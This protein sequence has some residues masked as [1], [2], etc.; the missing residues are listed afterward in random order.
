MKNIR[1]NALKE[2][3][4]DFANIANFIKENTSS[5]VQDILRDTIIEE[6]EKI[7]AEGFDKKEDETTDDET[8]ST[9]ENT[10]FNDNTEAE[11]T[12][13][14]ETDFE[15]DST[16][17]EGEESDTLETDTTVEV[18]EEEDSAPAD[19]SE[20]DDYKMDDENGGYDF[21]QADDETIVKVYKLLRNS[22]EVVVDLDNEKNKLELKD[23]QTGAEYLVNL[24]SAKDCCTNGT[25]D[26]GTEEDENDAYGNEE[27]EDD[28]EIKES[29][30]VE[31]EIMLNEDTNLGYTDNY[32]S[33]DVMTTPSV[34]EP[35]K[36]VN[37]WDAGVPKSKSKPWAGKNTPKKGVPFNEEDEMGDEDT[38][39]ES[40][41]IQTK[42]ASNWGLNHTAKKGNKL[43]VKDA[44]TWGT[45][46]KG[47]ALKECGDTEPI[48]EEEDLEEA[49]LSQSRWNDTHAAHNRVPAANKDSYRRQGMQKTSKGTTYRENG[50]SMD[51]AIIKKHKQIV[52]ENKE[53]KKTLTKLHN[54][55]MEAAVTNMNLGQIVKL[56]KENSTTQEEKNEIIAR[57]GKEAK[58][59][60]ESKDLYVKISNELQKKNT[61][62]INEEKQ[63]TTEGSKKI[64]E[65][66]IYASKDLMSSLELMHKICK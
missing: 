66:T 61:M 27:F 59:I 30:M 17:D 15:D 33:K 23:N 49:N 38:I 14:E 31:I 42:D 4:A 34:E 9:E 19:W 47:K 55:V 64:N 40:E 12:S 20:F 62:S 16:E 63:F 10:E 3:I 22:D 11:D 44:S 26:C 25:C 46:G 13:V 43:P 5:T 29:K 24:G 21:S 2:S 32:Q 36:N 18:D 45:N 53:M 1:T 7:V 39:E 51:E 54:I 52:A 37:D 50:G 58:T 28:N 60:Q 48:E 41:N 56:L 35:G 6:Y 65:N 57:F 8:V